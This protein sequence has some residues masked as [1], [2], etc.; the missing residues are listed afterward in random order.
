NARDLDVAVLA[1][2]FPFKAKQHSADYM[3]IL[4]KLFVPCADFRRTGSA[5]LDL[6]YFAAGLVDG[7]FEIGLKTWDF[8]S[9]ELIAREAG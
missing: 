2:G 7:F 8:L 4:T 9:G 3:N 5:S 6:A 1:T